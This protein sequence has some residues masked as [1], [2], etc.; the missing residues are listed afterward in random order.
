MNKQ[1]LLASVLLAAACTT[2]GP[3]VA[4]AVLVTISTE[5]ASFDPVGFTKFTFRID[6]DVQGPP[7]GK[8]GT[9]TSFDVQFMMMTG[10]MNQINPSSAETVFENNNDDIL[11]AGGNPMDDSQFEFDTSEWETTPGGESNES[12]TLLEAVASGYLDTPPLNNI[13]TLAHVVIQNSAMGKW[14]IETIVSGQEDVQSGTFS[15]VPETSQVLVGSVASVGLL[16]A[17]LICRL[18]KRNRLPA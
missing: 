11:L 1:R 6:P 5:P 16:G 4:E 7:T 13:F 8:T 15:V 17:Y 10:T 14:R 18:S 3:Q 12:S 9:V 2:A